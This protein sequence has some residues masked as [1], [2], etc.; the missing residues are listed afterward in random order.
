MFFFAKIPFKINT[1]EDQE[2]NFH[3]K[4]L[5]V[6]VNFNEQRFRS[7]IYMKFKKCMFSK[8]NKSACARYCYATAHPPPPVCSLCG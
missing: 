5:N 7:G 8:N 1:N 4:Q 6:C 3:H 2:F